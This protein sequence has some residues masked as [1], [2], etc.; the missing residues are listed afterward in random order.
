MTS[1]A[2]VLRV[3]LICRRLA[4]QLPE[5]FQRV[6]QLKHPVP[7]FFGQRVDACGLVGIRF[8]YPLRPSQPIQGHLVELCQHACDIGWHLTFLPALTSPSEPRQ[9]F[10]VEPQRAPSFPDQLGFEPASD[11]RLFWQAEELGDEGKPES[12]PVFF[13]SANEAFKLVLRVSAFGIGESTD[14]ADYVV[15]G[16]PGC[17]I[18]GSGRF[19][20]LR[21]ALIIRELNLQL[22]SLHVE[23]F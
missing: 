20:G 23:F 11:V 21:K 9:E 10:L 5:L 6:R 19:I 18:P 17:D 15:V 7:N 8:A 22:G 13:A 1:E 14:L 12:S 4:D 2:A 3:T 16:E